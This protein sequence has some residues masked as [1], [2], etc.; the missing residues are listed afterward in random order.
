[1]VH[2]LFVALRPPRP[3]RDSLIAC[4][5][6][7]ERARWQDDGQLH[8]TLR[9]VGEVDRNT[10]NDLAEALGSI[11][12]PAFTVTLADTGLFERKGVPHTLWAGVKRSDA[13]L[14]LQR[15]VERV[16]QSV[17]LPAEGRKFTAHVTLARLNGASGPVQSFLARTAGQRFG[18]W[19][20]DGF[21]LY[22]SHLR[23]EGSLY[24]EMVGYPL[25]PQD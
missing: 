14:R 20:A 16:C 9:Y 23:P 21:A 3:I 25:G 15:K 8:L 10:A 7:V 6:G 24:E 17:G 5:H 13:L 2:R 18:S 22:E 1:M 19:L 11:T 12:V 4:M